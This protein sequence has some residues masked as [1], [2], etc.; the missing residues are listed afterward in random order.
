MCNITQL[1]LGT[2][3]HQARL[4]SL[5]LHPNNHRHAT[6][7]STGRPRATPRT[8]KTYTHLN[9]TRL[10]IDQGCKGLP[11]QSK[12]SPRVCPHNNQTPSQTVPG[13]G[14][15][16]SKVCSPRVCPPHKPKQVQA[17]PGD[18][19]HTSSTAVLGSAPHQTQVHSNRSW[20][21]CPHMQRCSTR[22]CSPN[23]HRHQPT[24]TQ[25]RLQSSGLL[26]HKCKQLQPFLGAV[27]KQA[28]LQS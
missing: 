11:I 23:K 15:H 28:K 13:D 10:A 24:Q 18:G 6:H 7:P 4:Q 8:R 1:F 12:C 14:A 9:T 2:V 25:A 20:G 5:G 16:A 22:V 17:V 26:P 19:A 21:R 27:P 3:P